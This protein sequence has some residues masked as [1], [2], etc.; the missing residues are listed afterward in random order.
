MICF[1]G[2]AL[3]SGIGRNLCHAFLQAGF[4]VGGIDVVTWEGGDRD[5]MLEYAQTSKRF[6]FALADVSDQVQVTQAVSDIFTKTGCSTVHTLINNAAISNPVMS[7]TDDLTNRIQTWRRFIDVNLTG[8]FVLSEVLLP[9]M[10]HPSSIIHISSTRAR[11]SEPHCEGYGASKAGLCGLTHAQATSYG[12]RHIR[13]NAVLP[14]WIDTGGYPISDADKQW[15]LTGRVGVPADISSMCLFLSDESK[16]AFIT[17]QE[18]VVD[19]GVCK[20]MVY[21]P[22]EGGGV[23]E[24]PVAAEGSDERTT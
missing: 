6:S 16:A 21:P 5:E 10:A 18:F 13:V 17:G 23:E 8:A 11:Q 19:G 9:H 14:G 24:A 4:W 2:M 7:E 15:H 12:S 20:K 3:S 1:V 22:E